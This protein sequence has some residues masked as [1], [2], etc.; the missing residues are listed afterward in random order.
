MVY[1]L[2]F[3]VYGGTLKVWYEVPVGGVLRKQPDGANGARAHE[4]HRA[5]HQQDHRLQ[6]Q[7]LPLSSQ[8]GGCQK[9]A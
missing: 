3:R 8:W 5:A 7:G 2:G 9:H 6:M 1:G 4:G